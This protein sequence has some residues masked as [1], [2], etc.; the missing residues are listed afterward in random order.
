MSEQS[1][2]NREIGSLVAQVDVLNREAREI[3]AD[4]KHLRDE[5]AQAK[6]GWRTLLGIA[7]ILG[8][9]MSWLLNHLMGKQ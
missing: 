7:A 5:F 9:A 2:I 1:E 3:K 6:G 8:G 4:V